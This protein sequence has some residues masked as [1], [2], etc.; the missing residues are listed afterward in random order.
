M[1]H[2]ITKLTLITFSFLL[3]QI[4]SKAQCTFTGLNSSYCTN[5]PTTALTPSV[6]NF[7]QYY[8]GNGVIN[9]VFTP[10]VAGPGTH[11][12]SLNTCSNT[13]TSYTVTSGTYS[14]ALA[15]TVGTP[16]SL[17]DDQLSS[18]LPI[19]FTFNF[20]CTAYTDFYISSNGFITFSFNNGAN[21][22]CSGLSIPNSGPPNNL[23][24]YCWTDLH[25]GNGGSITYTTIGTAPNRRLVV[26][27]NNVP[28]YS[29]TPY[30]TCQTILYEST[31]VIEIH[32]FNQ[33]SGTGHIKTMGIEDSGTFGFPVAGRNASQWG[34]ST[35]MYRWTP[36]PTCISS[37][38]TIVAPSS[39]SVTGS[40]AICNG[41]STQLTANGN[42]TYTWSTNSNSSSISVSPTSNTTYS[43]A[44]TNSFGCISNAA[45]T[46]TV[47]PG[48]PTLAITSSTNA[49]CLG[50]TV[51]LT[52]T[53]AT[54]YTWTG[55]VTN[56][57][58]FT[59]TI[60]S[61]Y[62]VTGT[63]ACGTGTAATTITVAP[64][65]VSV[66]A[67]PTVVCAGSTSTLSAASAATS[68]SWFP[69]SASASSLI[70]S[71]QVNT[72]FT[73]AAS[74]GT[75]SGNATVA[76][77]A[78]PV[79]TIVASPSISTVCSG[80]PVSL[81]ASGAISYTW[82]PGNINGSA[83][84]VT[85]NV[86]T[87]YQV[88][89]SNSLGCTALANVVV[90]TNPSPTLNLTAN[91]NLICAGDPVNLNVSGASTYTWD[92]GS[93]TTTLSVNPMVTTIYSVTGESNGCAS[94]QTIGITVFIPTLAISGNTSIC[95][96][97]STTLTASGANTYAWNNGLTSAAIQIS[98]LTNTIYSLT[99]LTNSSGINCPSSASVQVIVKA[100]PSLTASA[101]RTSMCRNESNVINV[102]G[103]NTYTWNT[104]ANTSSIT[105][106]PSLV[107]NITYSLIGAGSNGCTNTTSILIRVNSCT[108]LDQ[109]SKSKEVLNIYPNPN[110]GSFEIKSETDLQIN[111][112]NEIG[113]LVKT[114][115]LN[116]E[117]QFKIQIKELPSGIY[118][119]MGKKDKESFT[120]K[121]VVQK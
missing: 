111:L 115:E 23:I 51:T 97:Q 75:C 95:N 77:N 34:T 4:N 70:V 67:S 47:F 92:N 94:S 112:V 13:T 6:N 113:Q 3:I 55:G 63:N 65:A 105:I 107:T 43:V 82:T 37:Q 44:A 110:N 80:V 52:A 101:T 26:S 45:V 62:V 1:K 109:L 18:N 17:G 25:P 83:I 114:F 21:G 29:N 50:R 93:N 108:G 120:Q 54:G 11:T 78:N 71:P 15:F 100:V 90:I 35:E 85:P 2:Q 12:I 30:V 39:I 59:P 68:Y 32:S 9:S 40:S 87:G 10:S 31:G 27:L 19:G 69:V 57:S 53:G 117:N 86:P 106:T 76:V 74:D 79:P 14:P 24:A 46:V 118:F 66:L 7:T 16:V 38:T 72:I 36:V 49:V 119:V 61:T 22:C 116:A 98:P 81:N 56:G 42:V 8:T 58:T 102:S 99:A 103:A 48:A 60:T 28:Y 96:G 104:G 73:V 41:A 91:T 64:L 88:V 33:T 20:F 89:G 5:S 121:I 84:T